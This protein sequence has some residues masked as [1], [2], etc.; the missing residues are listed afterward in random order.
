MKKKLTFAILVLLAP[1]LMAQYNKG[2]R[3]V[4]K[5]VKVIDAKV[6]LEGDYG[7][8]AADRDILW[9]PF[10]LEDEA[11]WKTLVDTSSSLPSPLTT[12]NNEFLA[13]GDLCVTIVPTYGAAEESDSLYCYMKPLIYS[14]TNGTWYTSA[15]DS[16]FLV[17]STQGKYCQSAISYLNWTTG[18]AYTCNL[19][20]ELWATAGFALYLGQNAADTNKARTDIRVIISY[21]R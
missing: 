20:N 2:E 5:S 16:T 19:S 18:K 4:F 15:N 9:V 14:P 21:V 13:T 7:V 10:P 17:F 6:V 11:Y 1:M 12:S 3:T 8:P